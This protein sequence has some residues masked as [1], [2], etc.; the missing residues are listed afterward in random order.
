[1][2][3]PALFLSVKNETGCQAERRELIMSH[4]LTALYERLSHDDEL[5]GEPD[6][7]KTEQAQYENDRKESADTT[8][9][10]DRES[11]RETERIRG[12][13]QSEEKGA[14]REPKGADKSREQGERH[15]VSCN[16][17]AQ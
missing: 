10:I 3:K 5:Q 13:R 6:G 2:Q 12:T 15:I 7:Y 17:N 9:K 4:D 16:P 8:Q 11:Q 14:D 1:M